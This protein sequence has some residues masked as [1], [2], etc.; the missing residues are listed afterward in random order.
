MAQRRARCGPRLP[1][2]G[3]GAT[4]SKPG[5]CA[6]LFRLLNADLGIAHSVPASL[7]WTP[8][9][10]EEREES[11]QATALRELETGAKATTQSMKQDRWTV[12]GTASVSGAP[13]R[14][15]GASLPIPL[16]APTDSPGKHSLH[17]FLRVALLHPAQSSHPFRGSCSA[18]Y[19]VSLLPP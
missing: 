2:F 15:L 19:P 12:S 8:G 9:E 16:S 5:R 14:I 13:A 11:R 6:T 10:K 7:C 3:R 1:R 18:F 17:P 4:H